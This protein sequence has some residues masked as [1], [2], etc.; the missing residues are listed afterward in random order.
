MNKQQSKLEAIV[1]KAIND[2]DF[3]KK[4]LADPA[5]TLA[6]EGVKLGKDVK[7]HVLEETKNDIYLILPSQLSAED[8]HGVVGGRGTI[9]KKPIQ[10]TPIK[11]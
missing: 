9:S 1:N 6:K 11:R 4:F 8:L 3:K 10:K 2:K 5:K 7:I